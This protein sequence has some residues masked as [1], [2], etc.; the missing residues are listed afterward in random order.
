MDASTAI[1]STRHDVGEPASRSID[2]RGQSC[3]GPL[4][5]LA[6]ALKD[7]PAGE[8]VELLATDPGSWSDVP[9]WARLTGNELLERERGGDGVFR[10]RIRK[11]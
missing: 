1:E 9:A 2:A 3:P 8:V 11:V 10:Y 5:T 7:V 6:R 4:V